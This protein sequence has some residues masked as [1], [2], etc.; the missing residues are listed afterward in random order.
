MYQ[1]VYS[2][3][4]KG[5]K[6]DPKVKREERSIG[7][8]MR[9]RRA[10]QMNV[11]PTV[12]S[13]YQLDVNADVLEAPRAA[14]SYSICE[15]GWAYGVLATLLQ[16]TGYRQ[17]LPSANLPVTRAYQKALKKQ[18]PM[19]LNLAENLGEIKETLELL[20]H[21]LRKL[22]LLF[23]DLFLKSKRLRRGSKGRGIQSAEALAATWLE[24]RYGIM[25]LV[26]T[27]VDL[28]TIIQKMYYDGFLI[29][30]GS[31]EPIVEKSSRNVSV[32]AS[33][34]IYFGTHEQV[35]TSKV[36]AIIT[37]MPEHPSNKWDRLGFRITNIPFVLWELT[38][39]SFV[40]E[41]VWDVS[42]FLRQF[43]PYEN[44]IIRS[45]QLCYKRTVEDYYIPSEGYNI[46]YPAGRT[47]VQ[48]AG[49]KATQSELIRQVNPYIPLAIEMGGGVDS[50]KRTLDSLSLG[51]SPMIDLVNKMRSQ[52]AKAKR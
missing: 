12:M 16:S 35:K 47:K 42:G 24:Y 40:L 9:A 26:Y 11:N 51:L 15:N 17:T 28:L 46:R 6:N 45:V 22:H 20:T 7:D 25:P 48:G 39:L 52:T 19:I 37:G 23:A 2:Y 30:K 1:Y 31:H 5:A 50:I 49:V 14:T 32:L 4:T 38:T 43:I 10:R 21:P 8:M 29:T 34:Y 13:K 27:S 36:T 44:R 41:W 18:D 33:E 3:R